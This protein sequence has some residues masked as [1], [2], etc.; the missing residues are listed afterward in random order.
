MIDRCQ[1]KY[2]WNF[3]QIL[4]VISVNDEFFN[5]FSSWINRFQ[6]ND[7][8]AKI[9]LVLISQLLFSVHFFFLYTNGNG[10]RFA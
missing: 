10:F 8:I 3:A 4:L 2:R 6:F 7:A 5:D 1:L 9:Y